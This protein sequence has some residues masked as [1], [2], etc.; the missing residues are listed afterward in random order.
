MA[1]P[2]PVARRNSGASTVRANSSAAKNTALGSA[3]GCPFCKR[4]GLPILPLRYAVV[5]NYLS[6]RR[7]NVSVQALFNGRESALGKV[8]ALQDH[9]YTIRTLR[10]GYLYVYLNKPGQWQVYSVT[11][12]GNLRLFADVDDLDEKA[13]KEMSAQ[14]KRAGDNIPASF[15]HVRDPDRTP[16]I[17]LAFSTARWSKAVRASYEA[18]PAKRMQSFDCK[19]LD[20]AP[21]HV[22]DAFELNDDAVARLSGWVEECIDKDDP[23]N[24]RREYVS[25]AVGDI[26]SRRFVWSSVHGHHPR[27]GQA[28][29]LAEFAN[30]YK[31]QRGESHKVAA[32]V[33][34]DAMGMVQETNGTRLHHIES[35]QKYCERVL[36]PLTISQSILG[37]KKVIETS[38]LDARAAQEKAKG[39]SDVQT[40]RI[41]IPDDLPSQ[42]QTIEVT[43]TRAERAVND[44]KQIWTKLAKRYDE[45]KR[46]QFQDT[47]E[48]TL[49][50]FNAQITQADADWSAWAEDPAWLAWLDDYDPA[51]T[52]QRAQLTMDCAPCLAGGVA[53]KHSYEVWKKWFGSKA[54]SKENPVYRGLFGNDKTLIG[55]LV[56]Q[57]GDV[58]KGDMLY[59]HARTIWESDEFKKHVTD[60]LKLA[61]A[62]IQLAIAGAI[63]DVETRLREV[64]QALD[65]KAHQTA[66]WAQQAVVLMF[67][68]VEVTLLKVKMT[69]G[70][71]QRLMSE[72]AFGAID[73]AQRAAYEFIDASG[74]KI[75]NL[76]VSGGYA[77]GIDNAKVREQLHE[78][79][80][81]TYGKAADINLALDA[82]SDKTK[83]L[84]DSISRGGSHLVGGITAHALTINAKALAAVERATVRIPAWQLMQLTRNISSKALRITGSQSF[85]LAAGALYFQKWAIEDSHKELKNKLGPLADEAQLAVVSAWTGT[86]GVATEL[87]GIGAEKAGGVAGRAALEGAGKTVAR[88]GAAI[89]AIAS[90]VDGIQ[91]LVASARTGERGDNDAAQLYKWAA[92]AYFIAAGFG[93]YAALT[94]STALL[95]PLGI[96]LGLIVIGAILVWA[97][98]NAEDT[99][100]EI[101]LDRCYFGFG[102]RAEG[103]WSDAQLA[104]ELTELNAI[105]VGLSGQ[106]G[107]SDNWLGIEERVT[108][109]ETIEVELKFGAFNPERS[110]YRW[111]LY[112]THE[113][114]GK[115]FQAMGGKCGLPKEQQYV[116]AA[117]SPSAWDKLSGDVPEK[118]FRNRQPDAREED[119]VWIVKESVEVQRGRFEKARLEVEYWPVYE[120]GATKATLELTDED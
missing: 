54:D 57:G 49:K 84:I 61:T 82:A 115:A 76:A 96:A 86:I 9:S 11:P 48:T 67:E 80:L 10:S 41:V 107:F 33:L 103:K 97:A 93:T 91:C 7:G 120:P 47:Y 28:P 14:C 8:P 92:G 108:G 27:S 111:V 113:E 1:T 73:S 38:T 53:D 88:I 35:R 18:D 95:G 31:A 79:T 2:N 100:A 69:L 6:A 81:W 36:R 34:N 45:A 3:E 22:P 94:A 70:D 59:G 99:Q 75:R 117:R 116:S 32:I 13:G 50:A 39:L 55:Y 89:G 78:F 72:L 110:A 30:C 62:D 24:G 16:K 74:R 51:K 43:T 83:V 102:E 77:L 12:E 98:L 104:K 52:D 17:W 56:P 15:I 101:W 85:I 66:T 60:H 114:R 109:Y 20:A 87:V 65:A 63:S 105:L 106:M 119:G 42:A 19:A 37:L 68:G 112:A 44:A 90:V 118:W 40:E 4:K 23:E 25:S 29:A 21:D 64:G 5:P 58:N 71:Y 26:P 46:K